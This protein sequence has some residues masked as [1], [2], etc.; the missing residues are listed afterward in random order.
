L[1]GSAPSSITVEQLIALSDEMAALVRSG[2]PLDRGLVAAGRDLRGRVGRLA[3]RVGGRLEQGDALAAALEAD[4]AAV[5][6]FY[7]A[8]VEAGLRSGRL[9]KALEG[10]AAYGRGFAET[11]RA[12][13]LAL[14]YPTMVVGLAYGLFL[15]FV[16]RVAPRLSETFVTFRLGTLGTL[17]LF[18]WLRAHLIY[19]AP[20]LPAAMVL[21]AIAWWESGRASAI[22]PG[23]L[24][25]LL[26]LIPGIGSVFATARAADFADL[27]ALMV[28]HGV[29][30]DEGIALAAEA[31]GSRSLRA[32]ASAIAEGLRRG[33]PVEV[34][35]SVSSRSSGGI[36]P[37][38]AW[39][40]ATS[41]ARGSLPPAL[42]HAAHGYRRR[43]ERRAESLRGALPTALVCLLGATT[44]IAY[45]ALIFHPIVA[46]WQGLAAPAG[47]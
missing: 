39:V 26:R 8:V 24:G 46:L 30:L 2:V 14:L 47:G 19:W 13:G 4:G 18:D 43:A 22:R 40:L 28:E 12:I 9:A 45:T 5:P 34:A 36:P 44:V 31:T 29:P 10:L 41:A 20:I 27:L 7:R 32:S 35:A 3:E 38:L 23:R 15:L 1:L 21:L 33:D 11:R 17:E 42:R 37:M 6:E 25:G 16:L